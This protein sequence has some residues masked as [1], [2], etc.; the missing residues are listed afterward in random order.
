MLIVAFQSSAL[1]LKFRGT[2][3]QKASSSSQ[4][5]VDLAPDVDHSFTCG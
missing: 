5:A 2:W 4:S 3:A 1:G